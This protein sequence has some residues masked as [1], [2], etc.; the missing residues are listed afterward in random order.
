VRGGGEGERREERWREGVS[1][2]EIGIQID[3]NRDR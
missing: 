1:E 3:R 2:M